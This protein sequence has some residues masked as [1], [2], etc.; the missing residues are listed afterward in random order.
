MAAPV[1]RKRPPQTRDALNRLGSP[2]RV[3]GP[4][5]RIPDPALLKERA[6]SALI[7]N[8]T[9]NPTSTSQVRTVP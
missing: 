3:P 6:Y 1:A 9:L 5:S 4:E 8:C 7:N 2:F